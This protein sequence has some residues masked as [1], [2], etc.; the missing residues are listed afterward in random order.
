MLASYYGE[1]SLADQSYGKVF[2][3]PR[4]TERDRNKYGVSRIEFEN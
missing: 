2:A 4:N 3:L 1:T